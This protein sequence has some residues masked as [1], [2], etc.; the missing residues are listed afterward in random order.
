MFKS[1]KLFPVKM[2][3][4]AISVQTQLVPTFCG[5]KASEWRF[6]DMTKLQNTCANIQVN[7]Q[8]TIVNQTL[9]NM[10]LITAWIMEPILTVLLNTPVNVDPAFMESTAKKD[11]GHCKIYTTCQ[12]QNTWIDEFANYICHCIPM[13]GV[14]NCLVP[15]IGCEQVTCS[16]GRTWI[17]DLIGEDDHGRNCIYA[18][19]YWKALP[20]LNLSLPE[21]IS[22][23]V[24]APKDVTQRKE[25]DSESNA[26]EILQRDYSGC[27]S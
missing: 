15:L 26:C 24:T 17:P 9:M 3:L 22:V 14:N 6:S 18:G 13:F 4:C 12:K 8:E 10:N 20:N 5:D 23:S 11:I 7:F 27:L 2:N 25:I 21:D 19:P 16:N 1:L